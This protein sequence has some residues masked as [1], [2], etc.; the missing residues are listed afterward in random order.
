MPFKRSIAAMSAGTAPLGNLTMDGASE[1]AT[2]ARKISRSRS[3]SR[4]A[5]TCIFGTIPV[6]ARSQIP[7]CEGPSSPVIPARSKT[8]VTPALCSATSSKS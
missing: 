3:P 7:W 1:I 2:H 8:R 6:S 5:P 4:G